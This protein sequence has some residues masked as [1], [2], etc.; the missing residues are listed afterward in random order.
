MITVKCLIIDDEPIAAQVIKNYLD[1]LDTFEVTKICN[2]GLQAFEYLQS[3]KVDLIFLDIQMPRITGLEFIKSLQN[4]PKVIFVTAYREY[5]FEGFELDA[6]DYLLKPVSFER[7]L[8]SI[9]KY[10]SIITD[11]EKSKVEAE[12]KSHTLEDF[13]WVRADRKNVKIFIESIKYIEGLKDYVKI[14]QGNDVVISKVP[15]KKMEELLPSEKFLR[16]HRS[17]LVSIDKISAFNNEDV[18]IGKVIIPIGRIY[19]DSVLTVLSA[20]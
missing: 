6:I 17:F 13:I 14:Y 7:F 8:K 12:P 2:N 18:E 1:R 20:R 19:K 16:I 3:S 15:L 9:N 11:K 10:N 4:P 5:A